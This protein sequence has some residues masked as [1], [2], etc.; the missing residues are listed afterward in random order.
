MCFY[1]AEGSGPIAGIVSAIGVA[2]VGAASSYFAYQKKKLCF[3]FQ[4]GQYVYVTE[5]CLMTY[6]LIS[7]NK[8]IL[9][10]L[11]LT[12]SHTQ[13]AVMHQHKIFPCLTIIIQQYG[14]LNVVAVV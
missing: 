11:Q 14:A 4:G 10:G 8:C 13:Q 5:I 7:H 1:P 3:K 9:T 6:T 2:L 12:K